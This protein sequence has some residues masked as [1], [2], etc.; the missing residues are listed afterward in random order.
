MEFRAL[1]RLIRQG[2]GLKLEFKRKANHPDKIARELVAFA[3]T[4]GGTLIVGVDDDG[5]IYGNKHS[6]EDHFAIS[7]F[8]DKYCF[9]QLPLSM[10][11]LPINGTRQVLIIKVE[12]SYHKPHFLTAQ[13]PLRRKQSFVRV[14]DMSITASREMVQILRHSNNSRGVSIEFGDRERQLLQTLDNSPNITLAETQKLLKT[15][16]RKASVLLTLM[17]RAGLLKIHP[18]EKG[19]S[20]SLNKGAF[21]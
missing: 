11:I 4:E 16:R 7:K 21:E 14:D 8:L 13:N 20:F 2:E 5:T 18:S 9:P 6:E 12:K 3:N 15:S 19:D 10:E 17:V 1:K